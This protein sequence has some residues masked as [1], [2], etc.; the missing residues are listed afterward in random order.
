MTFKINGNDLNELNELNEPILRDFLAEHFDEIAG[1]KMFALKKKNNS[2]HRLSMASVRCTSWRCGSAQ[3]CGYFFLSQYK[4]FIQL[5]GESDR[6][7]RSTQVNQLLAAAWARH[8]IK[9]TL[10]VIQLDIVNAYPSADPQAQFDVLAGTASTL[11]FSDYQGQAH[12]IACSK[13]GQQGDAFETV[14]FAVTTF[15]SFDRVF[16][17]HAARIGAAICD[18]VFIVAPFAEGLALAAELKQVLKQN[19][20]L[21]LD[22]PKFNCFFPGDRMIRINDDD[23]ARAL[24]Q[25]ALQ[26]NHQLACLSGM[27]AGIFTTGLRVA[28]VPIGNDEWVQQFVQAKAAAVQVDMGKL[29]IVSDGLTYYQMLRFYQNTRLAFLGRNTPTPLI[30][31]IFAE[32]DT[33]IFEAFCE[34]ASTNA[35][36]E[37]AAVFYRFVDMKLQLPHFRGRFGRIWCLFQCW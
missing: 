23:H 17:R 22:V 4:K 36:C 37:W 21:D 26:A 2:L 27:D 30:F 29:D 18:T 15:L 28:G 6:A 9:D 3:Q 25:N 13:G 12:K 16:A 14:S 34:N 35:H 31:N 32:V 5:G 11:H 20:D 19:L 33:T 8:S 24:F 7:T 10:V 1:C